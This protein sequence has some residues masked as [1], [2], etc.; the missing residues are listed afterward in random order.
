MKKSKKDMKTTTSEAELLTENSA[1]QPD[2]M[3]EEAEESVD[4]ASPSQSEEAAP[5]EESAKDFDAELSA[6]KQQLSEKEEAHLR[7][8]A[9]YDNYRKRSLKEKEQIAQEAFASAA[10]KFLPLLDNLER[11]YQAAKARAGEE[12]EVVKGLALITRQAAQTLEQAGIREIKALGETFDPKLH[13]AVLQIED[14]SK[15]EQEIVEVFEKGYQ[16]G[17]KVL[18]HA[19]VKVAN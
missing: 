15:G 2:Q 19:V 6:L 12:D 10:S 17:E 1:P 14:E 8:A 11:G 9:E 5:A 3:K 4:T 13:H 18:R 16:L 7:L